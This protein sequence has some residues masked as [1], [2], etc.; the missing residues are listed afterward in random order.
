[1]RF[2]ILFSRPGREETSDGFEYV[3]RQEGGVVAYHYVADGIHVLQEQAVVEFH[4]AVRSKEAYPLG[5]TVYVLEQFFAFANECP[6]TLLQAFV[7]AG[8]ALAYLPEFVVGKV[9]RAEVGI[10]VVRCGGEVAEPFDRPA[11]KA[12]HIVD[13]EQAYGEKDDDEVEESVVGLEEVFHLYVVGQRHANEVVA[14]VFG[15]VDV[16]DVVR[17]RGADVVG[18]TLLPCVRHFRPPG[19]VVEFARFGEQVV[20]YHLSGGSDDRE[21]QFLRQQGKQYLQVDAVGGVAGHARV[22]HLRIG[23]EPL[24]QRFGT[25]APCLALLE[26]HHS[27]GKD[28]EYDEEAEREPPLECQFHSSV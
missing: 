19:V 15:V 8:Y 11:E 25:V 21:A 12:P 16:R 3:E 5:R 17:G 1:M 24:L 13:E 10:G 14:E 6:F 18:G 9:R 20:V 28:D 27:G 7:A 26:Y 4:R 23:V 22:Y 2:E